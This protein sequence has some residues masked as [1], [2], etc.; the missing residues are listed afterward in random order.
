MMQENPVKAQNRWMQEKYACH[1]C[2]YC[3][4]LSYWD[5]YLCKKR[6][7]ILWDFTARQLI[8]MWWRRFDSLLGDMSFRY[9]LRHFFDIDQFIPDKPI[10]KCK[11]YRHSDRKIFWTKTVE[12]DGT[13][14][15]DNG[16]E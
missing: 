2:L 14:W 9:L 10:K 13:T 11:Y 16:V 8:R 1:L 12:M 4:Y 6:H 5:W 3:E 15:T 7:F